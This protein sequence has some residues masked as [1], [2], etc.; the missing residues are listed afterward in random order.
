[1]TANMSVI[2]AADEGLQEITGVHNATSGADFTS[3]SL[4]YC[5]TDGGEFIFAA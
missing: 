4:N 1:M 2:Y 5:V 3:E